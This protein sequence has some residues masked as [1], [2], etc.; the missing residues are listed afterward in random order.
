MRRLLAGVAGD[1]VVSPRTKRPK[2]E[3]PELAM[4]PWQQTSVPNLR[5]TGPA[6][7]GSGTQADAKPIPQA[8]AAAGARLSQH[9]RCVDH[10]P[11]EG[12]RSPV[13]ILRGQ[14][15]DQVLAAARQLVGGDR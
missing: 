14:D 5:S 15:P 7:L 11:I 1:E 4:E 10:V 3:Q 2:A 9:A 13:C 8:T 6:R 12:L